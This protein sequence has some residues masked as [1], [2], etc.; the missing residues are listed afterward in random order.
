MR[1]PYAFNLTSLGTLEVNE[2]EAINVRMIFDYY[3]AGASLGK[4]VDMLYAKQIPSPTG[5]EKWTRAAVDHL[6]SNSR[7]I[8]IVGFESFAGVQFE[9]ATRCNVDYDKAGTPRKETRYIFPAM[10]QMK[11]LFQISIISATMS[12]R[13]EKCG[14]W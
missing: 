10:P 14:R 11:S 1:I 13:D 6:L 4:V 7:Y 9:K 12:L 3:L 2:N 5:K 8:V